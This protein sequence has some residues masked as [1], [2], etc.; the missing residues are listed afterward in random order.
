[1]TWEMSTEPA[2]LR[3]RQWLTLCEI[4]HL[5]VRSYGAHVML[6]A[7]GKAVARVTELGRGAF[8]L[9][10]PDDGGRWEMLIIDA[11]DEV[12]SN[13]VSALEGEDD[14]KDE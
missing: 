8:G 13:L 3:V 6:E 11:L 7:R 12:M 2:A 4:G 14:D 9:S 5:R 10:F 1:M